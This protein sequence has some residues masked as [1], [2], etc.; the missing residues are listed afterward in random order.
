MTLSGTWWFEKKKEGE[1]ECIE[2]R[3]KKT[4]KE[5]AFASYIFKFDNKDLYVNGAKRFLY[6]TFHHNNSEL[7]II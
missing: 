7:A 2:H 1:C 4:V 5:R 3:R 6:F